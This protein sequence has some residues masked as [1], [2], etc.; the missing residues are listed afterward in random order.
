M[1]KPS[2]S[3]SPR[4]KGGGQQTP[5]GFLFELSG[6]ALCLDFVNTVDNRP[7]PER[8]ELLRRYDDLVAWAAQAGAVSARQAAGLKREGSRRLREAQAAL[9]RARTVRETLFALFSAAAAGRRLSA[10]DLQAL[11]PEMAAAWGCLRLAPAPGL[12]AQWTW[13]GDD[14]AL[15]RPLWPVLRSAAE[16]LTSDDMGRIRACAAERCAWLFIDRSKNHSR[17][18]CDMSVCGNRDKVRRHRQRRRS[19]RS[20]RSPAKPAAPAP[21]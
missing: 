4:V 1:S 5:A 10:A 6:G 20:R 14:A 17:R 18:W 21:S 11:H 12:C 3:R 2:A 15:D 9:D 13:A 16:L 8:Q 7:T 19:G